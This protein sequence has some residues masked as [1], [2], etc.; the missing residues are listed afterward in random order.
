MASTAD[1]LDQLKAK[2]NPDNLEGMAKFGMAVDKRLGVSVPE[3][4]RIA[5]ET[6]KDHQLALRL[7]KTGIA[8]ARI[9]A[10][11]IAEPDKLAEQ[12][13]DDWVKDIDSWDIGAQVCMNL[14]E[15]S[16]Y[17]WKKITEWS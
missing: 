11:M 9:T 13:M 4:R 12:Q 1:I 5:K 6:G 8:E 15:K 2:A 3:M 7:W 14:F 16:P 10:S 17:A